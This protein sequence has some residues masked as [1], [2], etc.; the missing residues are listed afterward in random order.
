MSTAS[1]A[2]VP[3][4]HTAHEAALSWIRVAMPRGTAGS[5]DALLAADVRTGRR[6][7]VTPAAQSPLGSHYDFVISSSG[8]DGGTASRALSTKG[9]R[10]SPWHSPDPTKLA[11]MCDLV[12]LS[13]HRIEACGTG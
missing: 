3:A 8:D 7:V 2:A 9:R 12:R 13:T 11:H 1:E 5:C 10:R 4:P 6:F